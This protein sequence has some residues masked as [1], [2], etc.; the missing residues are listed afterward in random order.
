[1]VWYCATVLVGLACFGFCLY[2]EFCVWGTCSFGM[3]LVVV[4]FS[5][6]CWVLEVGFVIGIR[7]RVWVW[8]LMDCWFAC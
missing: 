8:Y 7:L 1:M 5:D 2:L 4:E 6:C 3:A